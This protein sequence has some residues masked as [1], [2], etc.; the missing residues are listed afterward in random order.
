M[1]AHDYIH[2]IRILLQEFID[3][4][5]CSLIHHH[6]IDRL[7]HFNDTKFVRLSQGGVVLLQLLKV[8]LIKSLIDSEDRFYVVGEEVLQ[9]VL[10]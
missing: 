5:F 8:T 9:E 1:L 4:S 2:E 7:L 6:L 10:L 3:V